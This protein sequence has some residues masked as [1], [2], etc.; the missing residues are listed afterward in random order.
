MNK[1]IEIIK[2]FRLY[3]LKQ[4]EGLTTERLNHIPSG[5]KNNI[6]WNLGHMICTTQ[7]MCYVRSN[8]PFA[9]EDQFTKP[10]FPGTRPEKFIDEQE[11]KIIKELFIT[12]IDQLQSDLEQNKFASY[13]PSQTIPKVYGFEV[14]HINE[15]LSYL[16]HHDGYHFG[17]VASLKRLSPM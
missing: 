14:T 16:L 17:C 9:V 12:S 7:I 6:I 11:I 13:S 2:G 5:Y 4:I 3:M 15:A 10:Y 1:Q 8:S